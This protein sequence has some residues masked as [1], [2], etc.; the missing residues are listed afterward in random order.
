M[1]G[2][3]GKLL[4]I[5]LTRQTCRDEPLNMD[6]ARQ[7]IGASGLAARYLFDMT[8]GQTDPLGPD[9]PLIMMTAP[10]TGT[11]TPSSSRH[12]FCAR[13]PLTNLW[14]EAN[15]GGF[16]GHELRRA[17][18]DGIIFTGRA[19]TPVYLWLRAGQSPELRPAAHLWGLDTYQTREAVKAAVGDPRAR[20][21]C[22]GPAG[23]NLV[24]FAT[25]MN[26]EGRMAGRTGMGA[27]MGSKNLKAIA[28][29]GSGAL[30]LADRKRF[31]A[32]ARR[33]LAQVQED[34]AVQILK[35]LGTPGGLEYWEMIGGVP[36]RYWSQ[37]FFEGT[38]RLSGAWIAET[39]RTG[40]T[41]CW[42]CWVQCGSQVEISDGPHRTPKTDGP[43]HETVGSLGSNL[44][45]GDLAAVSRL[46]YL[47]DSLG[48]DTIST[49]G[50]IGLA[51]FL[52]HHEGLQDADFDGLELAWGDAEGVAALIQKIAYRQGCGDLLADGSRAVERR[53][54]KPGLAVQ[55][56]GLD[57][58]MHDPRALSGMA[59]VYLTSP[60]G[61]CH[62]KS[63]F[64]FVEAGHTFA[65]LGIE[66]DDHRAEAGKAPLVARH[67]NYRALVDASGCCLFVNVPT[68]ELV[69]QF[70]AAWGDDDL[71]L[72]DL[73]L[74]GERIF[75]LKRLLNL[76]FGLNPRRDEVFPALWNIPLEE[77][78]AEGYVPDWQAM[79]RE[80]YRYRDWDWD[81][82]FPSAEKLAALG[83]SDL[84][85]GL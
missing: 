71:A 52:R 30:P 85:D 20:V 14:G 43:E 1:H 78:G 37:G 15:I 7:F 83:L 32:S 39:I 64:Y 8:G 63:D 54:Q 62:N 51:L 6:W 38:H 19:E 31:K 73:L 10:L 75:N 17:G 57:P 40:S 29:R 84:I 3:L 80:Y 48:L 36:A 44:L 11:S 55:I 56:N 16:S 18:Y 27:V 41:G 13:S 34:M 49:G 21:A 53:Y 28:I 5:D 33:A 42:G 72:D 47:C 59:L 25:I 61:A 66:V 9:N 60:R 45:I 67:Q 69:E 22:I 81:T 58:G 82:G 79:L 2:Y 24:R 76:R 26:G 12:S 77:G 50:V 46:D 68:A 4:Y 65:E 23:E 74:A 70:R 35:E